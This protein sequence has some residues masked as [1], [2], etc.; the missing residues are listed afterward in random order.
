M[1]IAQ[2][3]TYSERWGS[4][5]LLVQGAGGNTSF[6]QDGT[7]TIKA[8]GFR[9]ADACARDIFVDVPLERA[10]AMADGG[11]AFADAG[12]R[13]ASIETSLHA[14]LPQPVVSHLHMI[15]LIAI[16]VRADAEAV[17]GTLLDGIDWAMIPYLKPGAAVAQAVRALV[18]ARG[19]PQVLVL[20]NHGIV[21]AGASFEQVDALITEVQ[22]RLG[23]APLAPPA[24]GRGHAGPRAGAPC[25]RAPR[26]RPLRDRGGGIALSGSCRL[27]RPR[28]RDRR[29]RCA[30]RCRDAPVSRTRRR[31]D[32]HPGA[33]RRGA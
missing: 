2:L 22:A 32:A 28:R 3:R 24:P 12:G 26:R 5:F 14:V 29:R 31:R 17:L 11:P 30:S 10:R 6:E 7:L 15:P 8:S 19:A 33:C 4:D 27:P 9:L 21:F 20:A 16:A 18:A 1:S 25:R 13:R 23:S